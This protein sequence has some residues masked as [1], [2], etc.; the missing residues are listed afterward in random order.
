MSAGGILSIVLLNLIGA[1]SPGPDVVLVTRLATKSRRHAYA[2]VLALH[3][4]VL[5][6]VSLTVFGA[7]ALLARFPQLVSLIELAGGVFL[8]LMGRGL[9]RGGY[10][11]SKG[12][13]RDEFSVA[14]SLGSPWR[15]AR[16]AL[17]TNLSNPKIVLFLAAIIAPAMPTT[18]SI[19][20]A[21]AIV[22][23]LVGTSLAYFLFMATIIS[24]R[25]VRRRLLG[26]GPWIDMGA[27]TIFVMFGLILIVRA[28]L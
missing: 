27:G 4:G 10:K 8:I 7:A 24:T 12:P 2:A 26:A 22:V 19:W 17:A 25:A 21:L 16:L 15:S 28:L 14:D 3:V 5:W 1:A 11:A 6:W 20:F 13:V 9:I 18:P 23:S